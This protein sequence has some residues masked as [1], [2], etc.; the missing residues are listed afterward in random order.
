M[1]LLQEARSRWESL[2]S[3]TARVSSSTNSGMPSAR[4]TICSMRSHPSSVSPATCRASSAPYL[5]PSLLSRVIV[6]C[7]CPSHGGS[8]SGRKV[9]IMST[10]SEGARSTRSVRS[11]SELK[12]SQWASSHGR[13]TGCCADGP[14]VGN[15][16]GECGLLA[17]LRTHLRYRMMRICRQP[18]ELAPNRGCVRNA[19]DAPCQLRGELHSLLLGCLLWRLTVGCAPTG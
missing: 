3:I 15:E 9:T 6:T 2:D 8:N 11:S 5:A 10:R 4:L 12:S 14:R 17:L 19:A 1:L 13:S 16:A 18:Q 7:A